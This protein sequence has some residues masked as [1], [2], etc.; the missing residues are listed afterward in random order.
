MSD[1]IRRLEHS[2]QRMRRYLVHTDATDSQRRART[3]HRT[4]AGV[5]LAVVV[6]AAVVAW[7]KPW[8]RAPGLASAMAFV[9]T[10]LK[11]PAMLHTLAGQLDTLASWWRSFTQPPPDAGRPAPTA[12]DAD[13]ADPPSASAPSAAK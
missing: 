6:V 7:H 3:R 12:T 10:C 9:L 2:R 4:W 13:Q 1:A 11:A 8:R 5:A